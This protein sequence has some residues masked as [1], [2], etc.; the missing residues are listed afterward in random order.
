M[1]KSA[2]NI[3]LMLPMM[4]SASLL[5]AVTGIIDYLLLRWQ[6]DNFQP[7]CMVPV[8]LFLASET[9]VVGRTG[10]LI[11]YHIRHTQEGLREFLVGN[12]AK[13]FE[14]LLPYY[15]HVMGRTF[16]LSLWRWVVVALMTLFALC[17]VLLFGGLTF[18]SVLWLFAGIMLSVV[19]CSMLSLLFAAF[20]YD[21][22]N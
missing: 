17:F 21:R 5:V 19:L 22:L 20:L 15:R 7:L 18:V 2:V 6:I 3:R 10:M 4:V 11:H 1:K 14:A 12:G 16:V 13:Q 8:L 9:L